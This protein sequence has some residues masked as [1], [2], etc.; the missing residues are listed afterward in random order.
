MGE[1]NGQ[2]KTH[3]LPL[4]LV[5]LSPLSFSTC[6]SLAL[7][8][9]SEYTFWVSVFSYCHVIFSLVFSIFNVELNKPSGL[10]KL[11]FPS[12]KNVPLINANDFI[13]HWPSQ[14][15]K[16]DFLRLI[17]FYT[18]FKVNSVGLQ[19]NVKWHLSQKYSSIG[20]IVS[21]HPTSGPNMTIWEER[22]SK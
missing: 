22:H 7:L 6:F 14:Q 20:K 10:A 16:Q 13:F 15:N 4:G 21:N 1:R 19:P 5:K 17:C 3:F 11:L 8:S 2:E 12:A 9:S 18:T